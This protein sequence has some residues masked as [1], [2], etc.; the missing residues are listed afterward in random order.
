MGDGG[1]SPGCSTYQADSIDIL[2]GLAA[3]LDQLP[4]VLDHLPVEY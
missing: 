1:C 2:D 4:A 3:D